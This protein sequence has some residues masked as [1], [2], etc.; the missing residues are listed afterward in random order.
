MILVKKKLG[1]K[2][3][4]RKK[5]GFKKSSQTK[6]LG[7]QWF[8]IQQNFCPK[9]LSSQKC[10]VKKNV[11][12]KKN[13]DSKINFGKKKFGSKKCWVFESVGSKKI[14]VQ[15]RFWVQKEILGSKTFLVRKILWVKNFWT[16][17]NFGSDKLFGCLISL[18][19]YKCQGL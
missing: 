4:C 7:Q 16:L 2:Q 6:F 9:I 3:F 15:K 17:K 13:W 14:G 8:L 1:P 12:L 19:V 18:L 10:Y 11:G 5:F